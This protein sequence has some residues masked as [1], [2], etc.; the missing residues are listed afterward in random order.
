MKWKI[1][2]CNR[3]L[4]INV[5][6]YCPYKLLSFVSP[7]PTS[8]YI[9]ISSDRPL[10]IMKFIISLI[11]LL[12]LFNSVY[13]STALPVPFFSVS[14]LC[15]DFCVADGKGQALVQEA[16]DNGDFDNFCDTGNCGCSFETRT[17]QISCLSNSCFLTKNLQVVSVSTKQLGS[18]VVVNY[19]ITGTILDQSTLMKGNCEVSIT[20]KVVHKIPPF[21]EGKVKH[22]RGAVVKDVEGIANGAQLICET[23]LKLIVE[24]AVKN[25][26]M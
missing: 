17:V 19:K 8:L 26:L 4:A 10:F 5:R 9:S 16:C 12:F 7:F 22:I 18:F 15:T 20:G 13:S 14:L 1:N 3:L 25:A 2:W 21:S 24:N 23:S 11:S 6:F